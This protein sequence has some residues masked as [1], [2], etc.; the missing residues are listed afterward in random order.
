MLFRS[1]DRLGGVVD[2]A[3][4]GCGEQPLLA[5]DPESGVD[6]EMAA[7]DLPVGGVDLAG[8]AR[9]DDRDELDKPYW[10]ADNED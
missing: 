4:A 9:R 7:A 10:T 3:D 1:P 8:V 6:D 5:E 2:G